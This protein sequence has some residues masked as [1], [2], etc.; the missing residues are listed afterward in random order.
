MYNGSQL[1]QENHQKITRRKALERWEMIIG[2]C[3]V[4]PQAIW[5]IV[6]SLMKRDGPKAPTP[7]HGPSGFKYRPLQKAKKTAD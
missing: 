7:I 1:G 6:K 4:T 3:E 2:N 5:P